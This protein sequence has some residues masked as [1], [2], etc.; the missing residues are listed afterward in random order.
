MKRS[1][2]LLVQVV[3][4]IA[5]ISSQGQMPI[6][7]FDFEA[8]TDDQKRNA[9]IVSDY[10]RTVFIKTGTYQ[11]ISRSQLDRILQEYSFQQSGIT[12]E[13]DAIAIGKMLNA[14]KAVTGSIGKFGTK[15]IVNIQMIDLE[16]AS[17]NYAETVTAKSEDAL[18]EEITRKVGAI[19]EGRRAET[20]RE[21]G[22]A[23]E[24]EGPSPAWGLG[25]GLWGG[26]FAFAEF[27]ILGSS[28][29]SAAL[30][31][32]APSIGAALRWNFTGGGVRKGIYLHLGVDFTW[33]TM[34]MP[35]LVPFYFAA[36]V[37]PGFKLGF[38]TWYVDLSAGF[39]LPVVYQP[40]VTKL[41]V[42]P[43]IGGSLRFGFML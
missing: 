42:I 41:M 12:S 20:D 6:V 22:K 17:F 25:A 16:T 7:I 28:F 26:A 39:S 29:F 1:F 24:S 27:P 21:T 31:V 19:A 43:P 4:A 34:V 5:G 32:G 8:K 11:V 23:A 15:L 3:C 30:N 14:R 13:K 35:D 40:V 10:V 33:M 2:L 36:T 37:A 38:K 18:L 9:E